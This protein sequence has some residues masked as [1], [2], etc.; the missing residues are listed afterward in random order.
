MGNAW[1]QAGHSRSSNSKMATREPAGAR[2]IEV[3][4]KP[5]V[6]W[7]RAERLRL[8][9]R[10]RSRAA[11]RMVRFI[12]IR[13]IRLSFVFYLSE[14]GEWGR[15]GPTYGFCTISASGGGYGTLIREHESFE[16]IF[17]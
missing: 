13:R 14:L 7:A 9:G 4:L 17:D 10:A 6:P 15:R 3:S 12:D 16:G 5:P 8:A 1:A 11:A 2:S